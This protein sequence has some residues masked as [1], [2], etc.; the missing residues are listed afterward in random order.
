MSAKRDIGEHLVKVKVVGSRRDRHW[1]GGGIAWRAGAPETEVDFVANLPARY[2]PRYGMT[3]RLVEPPSHSVPPNIVSVTVADRDMGASLTFEGDR[4]TGADIPT[5][6]GPEDMARLW[7]TARELVGL[8]V[9]RAGG[10][11]EGRTKLTEK[12]VAG[13]IA[14]FERNTWP[15]RVPSASVLM[16]WFRRKGINV[17]RGTAQDALRRHYGG[18]Y[19]PSPMRTVLRKGG[20]AND[21]D[22]TAD[23]RELA[24][25]KKRAKKPEQ[26]T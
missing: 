2:R 11:P 18:T 1:D 23:L 12:Q 20:F 3:G 8:V 7:R 19:H 15:G 9:R 13:F 16:G 25:L 21:Q 5:R 24:A 4:A 22:M 26:E 6:L 14:D 10:R 17:S